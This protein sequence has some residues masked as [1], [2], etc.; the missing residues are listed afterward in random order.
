MNARMQAIED[1]I[2]TIDERLLK[3][4]ALY[5]V[6][7]WINSIFRKPSRKYSRYFVDQR[8]IISI[9]WWVSGGKLSQHFLLQFTV[10]YLDFLPDAPRCIIPMFCQWY[11]CVLSILFLAPHRQLSWYFVR[12]F[13]R[14]FTRYF[15]SGVSLWRISMLYRPSHVKFSR[16]I[17][18]ASR[19]T[20]RYFV[21]RLDGYSELFRTPRHWIIL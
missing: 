10:N 4:D 1:Q 15:F 11:I 17:F 9:F 21:G 7:R 18:S 20:T 8:S 5:D 16:N 13:Q 3:Y 12:T 14:E 19:R 6:I 2:I